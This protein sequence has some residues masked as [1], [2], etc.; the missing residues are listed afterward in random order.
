MAVG[1]VELELELPRECFLAK[2]KSILRRI[3]FGIWI[4]VQEFKFIIKKKDRRE[5][6]EKCK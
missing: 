3:I 2:W 6:T 4:F 1:P 5:R